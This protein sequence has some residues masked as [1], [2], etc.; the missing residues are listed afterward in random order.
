MSG[1][2]APDGPVELPTSDTPRSVHTPVA[3]AVPRRS[4]RLPHLIAIGVLGALFVLILVGM[5]V[6]R[7]SG[8][9]L[10]FGELP[11]ARVSLMGSDLPP[12]MTKCP[13]SGPIQGKGASTYGA[14][15]FW[16]VSYADNCDS[17]ATPP[18][19]FSSVLEYASEGAAVAAYESLVGSQDCTIA[20]GCVD[21]LGQN[22]NVTCG[23]STAGL[24]PGGDWGPGYLHAWDFPGSGQYGTG[25]CLG[26][27]QRK[28]YVLTF[29][30]TMGIDEAKKAISR[31]D[32]RAQA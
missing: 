31:M 11:A 14:I 30:G 15:D 19:V 16:T 10:G 23:T 6:Y 24:S 17:G 25:G 2:T 1:P 29:D 22:S 3:G 18:Y 26:T 28:T 9:L 20:N 4:T 8:S 5:G 13:G 32:A 27:W 12:G 21:G 7:S